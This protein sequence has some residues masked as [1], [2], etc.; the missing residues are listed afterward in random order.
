MDQLIMESLLLLARSAKGA[1]CVKLIQDIISSPSV[2]VF[3]EF[4]EEPNIAE[5]LLYSI[6]VFSFAKIL[7]ILLTISCWNCLLTEITRT[8][9]VSFLIFISRE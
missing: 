1:A 7:S 5:V 6:N 3:G 2:F 8:I 4:L 9:K